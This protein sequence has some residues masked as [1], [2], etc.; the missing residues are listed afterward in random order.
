MAVRQLGACRQRQRGE[1]SRQSIR[2]AD[3]ASPGWHRTCRCPPASS[4]S[5]MKQGHRHPARRGMADQDG[6]PAGDQRRRGDQRSHRG[7]ENGKLAVVGGERGFGP[8]LQR[9]RRRGI[10]DAQAPG[11]PG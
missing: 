11:P 2:P 7:D 8:G 5:S 9:G 1:K 6:K 4:T 10:A 3:M